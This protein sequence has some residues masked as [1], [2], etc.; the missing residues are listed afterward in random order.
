MSDPVTTNVGSPQGAVLSTTMFIIM[1]A[2]IGLWSKSE[3]FS[4]AD[5]TCSTLADSNLE[6]LIQCCEEEA[7]K[8]MLNPL[9]GQ[10]NKQQAII[11]PAMQ[12]GVFLEL[13]NNWLVFF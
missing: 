10:T 3:I 1:V 7:Q 2:D 4:Y 12:P 6:L 8:F 11:C 9:G 13:I 5:D